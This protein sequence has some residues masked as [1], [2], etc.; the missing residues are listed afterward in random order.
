M[1]KGRNSLT[2][3]IQGIWTCCDNNTIINRV[4]IHGVPKKLKFARLQLSREMPD[5]CD[6]KYPLFHTFML[7]FNSNYDKSRKW[8][9]SCIS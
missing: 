4:N 6:N 7:C 1:L 5:C 8:S 3:Y 2:D 9:V